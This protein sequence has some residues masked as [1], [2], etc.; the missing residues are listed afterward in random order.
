MEIRAAE[1]AKAGDTI[2]KEGKIGRDRACEAR[3]S[4]L[5]PENEYGSGPGPKQFPRTVERMPL[6]YFETI[7][8]LTVWAG[9][10]CEED[11]RRP[12]LDNAL[13]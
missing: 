5:P 7:D 6:G 13:T 12:L 8:E 2:Q 10:C 11:L 4:R 9:K 3:L 1:G